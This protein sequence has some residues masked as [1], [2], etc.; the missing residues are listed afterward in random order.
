MLVVGGLLLLVLLLLS[1]S[2][3]AQ[4]LFTLVN[5]AVELVSVLSNRELLVVV[6]WNV[7]LPLAI[8]LVLWVVELG[9]I[10]VFKGLFSAQTLVGVELQQM[11]QK[12]QSFV[13]GSG[14]HITKPLLLHWR[15]RL[16]HGLGEGRV[17]RFDVLSRWSPGDLHHAVKLVKRACAWEAGFAQQELSENATQTP[18][19]YT[20]GIFV[21]A[22]QDLW[23]AVPA[24]RHIISQQWLLVGLLVQRAGQAEVGA[25]HVALSVQQEV[26]GLEVTVQQVC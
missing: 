23:S 21:A 13:R 24:C 9:H 2:L 26:A 8:R 5:V 18:H 15:Q 6:D 1:Q 25:L 11:A 12:V 16:K 4:L 10:L 19:I 14:E 17:D 7:D 3:L 22:K 20:L